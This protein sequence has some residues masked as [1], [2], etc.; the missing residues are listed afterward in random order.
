MPDALALFYQHHAHDLYRY[1][2]ERVS[3]ADAEDLVQT[4]FLNICKLDA[5]G[6]D[7]VRKPGYYFIA[8]HHL[9][10]RFR[11]K[12]DCLPSLLPLEDL[13]EL[14]V[15]F[16]VEENGS[17]QR[18]QCVEDMIHQ[19][20]SSQRDI[21]LM[22]YHEDLSYHEIAHRLG[23]KYQQVKF[24]GYHGMATLKRKLTSRAPH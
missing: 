24:R 7:G 17:E 12:Q 22:R 11:K 2:R 10:A 18:Q 1:A 3:S 21:L 14:L 9:I 19:L 23:L 13:E 8:L 20:P 4:L 6:C 16:P 15:E 5:R